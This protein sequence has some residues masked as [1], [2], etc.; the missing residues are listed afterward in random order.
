MNDGFVDKFGWCGADKCDNVMLLL[1][2]QLN[3]VNKYQETK[4]LGVKH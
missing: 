2:K 3:N 4:K 1:F